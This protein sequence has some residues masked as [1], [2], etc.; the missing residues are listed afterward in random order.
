MQKTVD[1]SVS[2]QLKT[3]NIYIYTYIYIYTSDEL[4]EVVGYDYFSI[5]FE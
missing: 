1:L 5:F 4:Q 2:L 3:D